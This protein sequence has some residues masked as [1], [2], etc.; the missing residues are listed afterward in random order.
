RATLE[1]DLNSLRD[2]YR[3][4]GFRD[5]DV[6]S[7]EVDDYD[8]KIGHIAL[9]IEIKEGP[10]WFVSSLDL[11]G[12]SETDRAALLLILHSTAGQP[13]SDL[14]VASDRDGILEYYYNN[15]YPEATFEFNSEPAPVP[16][17]VSLRFSVTPGHQE[18]VR[19]VLVS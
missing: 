18:F 13:Y 5:I 19:D 1:R 10:Q 4:N 11:E 14:N 2:V 16:N 17:R 15:G 8:G 3:A 9:F 7:K 6:T 12:V